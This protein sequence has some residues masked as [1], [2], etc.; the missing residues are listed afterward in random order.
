MDTFNEQNI[1]IN[2]KLLKRLQFYQI[3]DRNGKKILGWNVHQLFFIVFTIISIIFLCYGNA[4]FF[5]YKCE[6]IT[7]MDLFLIFVADT[8]VLLSIWKLFIILN[9]REN[10]LDI[11]KIMQINFLRSEQWSNYH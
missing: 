7:N 6:T 10:I 11:I 9:H 5:F 4:G 8:Q 2:L 1:F 3:F